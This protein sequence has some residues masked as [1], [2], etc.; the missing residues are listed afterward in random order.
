M[1]H[2]FLIKASEINDKLLQ[3]L[4]QLDDPRHDFFI[5][6][7]LKAGA[8]DELKVKNVVKFSRI[9]FVERIKGNWG[10]FL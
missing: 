1:K 3:I 7:D 6:I 2:A 10:D 5:H 9:R 8:F 4:K